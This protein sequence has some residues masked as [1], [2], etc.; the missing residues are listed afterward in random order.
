[1]NAP[2]WLE[3]WGLQQSPFATT[4]GVGT[5][6][7]SD[8]L[9]E[10]AARIEYLVAEGR[11]VGALLGEP[12]EGKTTVLHA[13]AAAGKRS[14]LRGAAVAMVDAVALSPRELLWQAASQLGAAPDPG[15]DTPRLWRRVEDRLC[16]LRWQGMPAV[17]LVDD[18]DAAGPD[19]ERT[20]VR[21]AGLESA[22]DAR[23]TII[24]ATR[25]ARLAKLDDALLH[26]I[27]L[28]V[29]LFP[30]T[31]QDTAGFVQHALIDAGCL[32]PIFTDA[33]LARLHTQTEGLPRHVVRL[34]DFALVAGAGAGQSQIGPEA[35]DAAFDELRW[36]PAPTADLV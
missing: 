19:A 9:E 25:P 29:D 2:H 31:E 15:D 1:M 20:L 22:P 17:L 26:R 33:A 18:A 28:R 34:A 35:I 30:W 7:P 21:L 36:S 32:S 13:T 27:D 10:A 23:W 16:H 8:A 3:H 12:G 14:A 24:L 4:A 6:Y 5:P 11:R